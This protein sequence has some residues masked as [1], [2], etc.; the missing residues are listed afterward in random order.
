MGETI[1]STWGRYVAY[2]SLKSLN[3][4]LKVSLSM[5]TIGLLLIGILLGGAGGYYGYQYLTQ[6]RID[7]LESD[8]ASLTVDLTK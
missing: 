4:I 7:Q 3:F 2:I 8:V 1:Q 6:P 5:K